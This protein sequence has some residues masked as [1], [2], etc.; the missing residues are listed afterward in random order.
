MIGLLLRWV[1]PTGA[2]TTRPRVGLVGHRGWR[3]CPT[4]ATDDALATPLEVDRPPGPDLL[5]PTGADLDDWPGSAGGWD[6]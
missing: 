5:A 3:P 1:C 2:V 4:F 6:A